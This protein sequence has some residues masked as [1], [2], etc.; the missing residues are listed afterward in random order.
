MSIPWTLLSAGITDHN[1]HFYCGFQKDTS[2]LA[3]EN[4]EL[5]QSLQTLEAQA[6]LRDGELP[7]CAQGFVALLTPNDERTK[8]F[9]CE[10]VF[11]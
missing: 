1:M 5:K 2:S 10:S 4:K 11:R 6:Q 9:V 8:L 7:L 3:S